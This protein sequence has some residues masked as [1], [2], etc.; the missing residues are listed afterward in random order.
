M[1]ISRQ[2]K[3]IQSGL[4]WV[5][6]DLNPPQPT[7]IHFVFFIFVFMLISRQIQKSKCGLRW[8][9]VDLNPPQPTSTHLN[10]L[11]FTESCSFYFVIMSMSSQI[12]KTESGL[13]WVRW[14]ATTARLGGRPLWPPDQTARGRDR[15]L[16]RAPGMSDQ[17]D[18][19]A[20]SSYDPAD[21]PAAAWNGTGQA[22]RPIGRPPGDFHH[23]PDRIAVAS[24]FLGWD[25]RI[26]WC[27]L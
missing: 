19:R 4:R 20:R 9:E 24:G 13:R 14:A 2:I 11:Q 17:S 27:H 3:K 22:I 10:S 5:E 7:S 23:P 1:L 6:V 26:G 16:G 12:E 8:V 15:L 21:A 18:G 25:G